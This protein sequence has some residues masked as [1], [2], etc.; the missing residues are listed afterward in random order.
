MTDNPDLH[1]GR[2]WLA[3]ASDV[4]TGAEDYLSAV[5]YAHAAAVI[6]N[7]YVQL[8]GA[9]QQAAASAGAAQ[10]NAR[11]FEL[12]SVV[13][14]AHRAME[15]RMRAEQAEIE[16]RT[17]KLAQLNPYAATLAAAGQREERA[18]AEARPHVGDPAHPFPYISEMA[19]ARPHDDEPDGGVVYVVECGGEATYAADSDERARA[20]IKTADGS[21]GEMTVTVL[22]VDRG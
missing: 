22:A 15:D 11:I 9:E 2:G 4:L 12:Q 3:R 16:L 6:G 17:Q 13:A 5:E 20:W 19:E 18:E 1:C 21:F 7:G 10:D 14:D 8:A